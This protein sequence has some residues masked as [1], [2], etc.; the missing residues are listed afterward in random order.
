MLVDMVHA[1]V[2]FTKLGKI[3]ISVPSW[4]WFVSQVCSN[5]FKKRIT[6]MGSFESK[7]FD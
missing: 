2:F 3:Q 1:T 4:T 5:F 7:W 6:D